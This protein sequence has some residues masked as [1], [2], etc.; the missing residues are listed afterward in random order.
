MTHKQINEAIALACGWRFEDGVWMWT[1]NGVDWT[2]PELRDY[3][4][5]L[6]AMYEAEQMLW[7]KDYNL[8]YDYLDYIGK[9]LMPSQWQ[10]IVASD[11]LNLTARDKAEAFLR[12]IGKWEEQRCQ[13]Q[14]KL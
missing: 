5:D 13:P 6:N 4:E 11:M 7:R 12:T 2:S 10:R 9:V 14:S 1:A 8:R 3:C